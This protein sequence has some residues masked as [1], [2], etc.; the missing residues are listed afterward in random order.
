M[1]RYVNNSFE[2]ANIAYLT[3]AGNDAQYGW[4]ILDIDGTSTGVI[5]FA[6]LKLIDS[7]RKEEVGL[8]QIPLLMST[9]AVNGSQN[10]MHTI[11]L[12]SLKA[13]SLK[14]L[15]LTMYVYLQLYILI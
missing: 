11:V 9:M 13:L 10:G 7:R 14:W 15:S 4:S 2:N 1:N 8:Y 3:Y 6:C 5:E 12:F